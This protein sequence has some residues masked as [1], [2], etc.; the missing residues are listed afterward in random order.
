MFDD[1]GAHGAETGG[2]EGD[3][4]GLFDAQLFRVADADAVARVGC[5]GGEDGSSSIS[6]AATVPLISRPEM[7]AAGPLTETVP[8]SSP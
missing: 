5:D 4:V 1:D 6:S 7:P 2:G 3:A 8:T